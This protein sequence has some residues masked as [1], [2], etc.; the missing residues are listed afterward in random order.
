ML[1]SILSVVC[2]Y[3]AW[4]VIYLGGSQ[5]IL[6]LRAAAI[7]E[8]GS[9]SDVP[10]LA[11]YLALSII[12]SLV[13]GSVAVKIADR[14]KM[15]HAGIVAALLLATGIPVQMSIWELLPVWYH[16]TFLALLVPVTLYG[17]KLAIK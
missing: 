3:A 10:T 8:D 12:A 9:T 4:T 11:M 2:G 16:A 6:A 14:S 13:A 1:K 7:R 15:M 17:A 5:L